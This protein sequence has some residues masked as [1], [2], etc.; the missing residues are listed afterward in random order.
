MSC[1]IISV[2]AVG[3]KGHYHLAL[4][5]GTLGQL[6]GSKERRTGGDTYGDTLLLGQKLGCGKGVLIGS[7]EDLII[8]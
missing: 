4:I 2:A 7:F 6:D 5:L 3:K 1:G 8:Y